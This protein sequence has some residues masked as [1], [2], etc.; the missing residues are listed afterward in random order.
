MGQRP[1]GELKTVIAVKAGDTPR[2]VSLAGTIV[3]KCPVA[4]CWFKLQDRTGTIK[5]DTKSAGFVV[6]KVP[7]QTPVTIVGTILHE[8]DE[9]IIEASGLRY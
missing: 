4:G 9:T 8:G 6:V 3:E 5:V 1:E 2:K 7:L